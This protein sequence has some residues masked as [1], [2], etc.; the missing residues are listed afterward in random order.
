MT[1]SP[2][3]Q[4]VAAVAVVVSVLLEMAAGVAVVVVAVLLEM[5]AA[6][7]QFRVPVGV[8][9]KY[10]QQCLQTTIFAIS[11]QNQCSG[12]HVSFNTTRIW[13]GSTEEHAICASVV[14][15]VD[16]L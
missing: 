8:E 1:F 14:L 3:L 9:L 15:F 6:Q 5:V 16:L 12:N 10:Q 7:L 11:A 2:W 13:T 4:H